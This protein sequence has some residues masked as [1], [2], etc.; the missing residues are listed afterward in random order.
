MDP[1]ACY[2][3]VYPRYEEAFE[4]LRRESVLIQMLKEEDRL[5]GAFNALP[6]DPRFNAVVWAF[7]CFALAKEIAYSYCWMVAHAEDSPTDESKQRFYVGYYADN[8][9]TRVNSF[10]DKGALLAWSYYC[11]F[12]PDRREEVL[13]FSQILE[14][15]RCPIRFG[16]KIKGQGAFLEQLD[17]LDA[18]AFN[19]ASRYRHL[20]IHRRE[21]KVLLRPPR[22]SDGL[23]YMVPLFRPDEIRDFDRKLAESYPNPQ[24]CKRIR[25]SCFIRDTLFD[26]R[27][28]E[29]EFWNFEEV[30]AFTCDCVYTC[31]DVAKGLSAVLRRRAPLRS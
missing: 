16:L 1:Y 7:D 30:K 27:K 22:T 25:K 21:P 31:L 19:R 8:C 4:T 26:H 10:R 18:E 23:G 29:D 28:T 11:A 9:I 15:L 24:T 6:F 17:K 3:K 12:N 14:R 20:K 2:E 13:G 5:H